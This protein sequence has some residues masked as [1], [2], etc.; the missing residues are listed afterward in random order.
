MEAKEHKKESAKTDWKGLVQ[1][2]VA[3]MLESIGENVSRRAHVFIVQLKKRTIGAVLMLIGGIF[4]LCGIA[5]L[6][7]SLLGSQFQWVG[8]GVVGI[9]IVAAGYVVTKE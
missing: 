8:W 6:I 5:I 1:G 4:L 2:F 9:V 7:N 3:N